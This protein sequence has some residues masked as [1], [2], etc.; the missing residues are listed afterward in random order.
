M[1]D[2]LTW[3]R[4]GPAVYSSMYV[5]VC[6]HACL[7]EWMWMSEW[8]SWE[9]VVS[10]CATGCILK[11]AMSCMFLLLCRVRVRD[12]NDAFKELGHM[13]TLHSSSGQPLTKLMVMQQAVDIITSLEQQVRGNSTQHTTRYTHTIL[14]VIKV[15]G[16]TCRGVE[17]VMHVWPWCTTFVCDIWPWCTGGNLWWLGILSSL[18]E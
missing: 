9:I 12:I 16:S 13:V 4:Y 8:V 15:E 6:V 18:L 5:C 14:S 2:A 3:C 7:C 10:V 1:W 17:Q 11:Q